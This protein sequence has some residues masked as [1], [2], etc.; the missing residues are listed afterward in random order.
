MQFTIVLQLSIF[1]SWAARQVKRFFR[2]DVTRESPI[3]RNQQVFGNMNI[4]VDLADT[5]NLFS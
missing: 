5:E 1:I 3:R 4:N 2:S